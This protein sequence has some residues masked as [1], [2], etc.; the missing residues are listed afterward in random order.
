MGNSYPRRYFLTPRSEPWRAAGQPIPLPP[1][2]FLSHFTV[3]LLALFAALSV[4]AN[5]APL[6]LRQDEAAHSIS[7]FR[8]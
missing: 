3:T 5:A 8:Q 7:A 4:R 2:Q 6:A 1:M